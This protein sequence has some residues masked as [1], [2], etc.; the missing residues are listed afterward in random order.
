MLNH[1]VQLAVA[2][3]ASGVHVI[4][5]EIAD[6]VMAVTATE[7]LDRQL[8]YSLL[9]AS[10][11][12]EQ[13]HFTVFDQL[14]N[15]IFFMEGL[16]GHCSPSRELAKRIRE[17]DENPEPDALIQQLARE[18]TLEF[19]ESDQSRWL[20]KLN[21][22]DIMTERIMQQFD[23][24]GA[25]PGVTDGSL[26]GG[27]QA[28]GKI[29]DA[30]RQQVTGY[31]YSQR[32]SGQLILEG[33]NQLKFVPFN[34]S[35]PDEEKE[36]QAMIRKLAIRIATQTSSLKLSGG[37]DRMNF[38]KLMR[39]S[40]SS[41]GVPLDLCMEHLP[42]R[43]TR[44]YVLLDV[45]RSMQ[46]HVAFFLQMFFALSGE[47]ANIRA[48]VFVGRVTE[49]THLIDRD[50][51]S[52]SVHA[53]LQRSSAGHEGLTDYGGAI[54]D[55]NTFYGE[56]ITKRTTVI[57]LGDARTNRFDPREENL[58]DLRRRCGNLFWLNPEEKWSWGTGDSAM[59]KYLPYCHEAYV[60]R[61]LSQL[62]A[63]VEKLLLNAS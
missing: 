3:R 42:K 6:A 28:M 25:L 19:M 22:I 41:G 20:K 33:D 14:F 11:V 2:L 51:L 26:T 43:K 12:K 15:Q 44:L 57:I 55:F 46:D 27:G 38:R 1:I 45:S 13:R 62:E 40:L 54:E 30:V 9:R 5:S 16:A 23:G 60:V 53:L 56:E 10:M 29:T 24:Q 4:S 31:Q 18:L 63:F 59:K 39:K 50:A 7:T 37:K 32:P 34:R 47:F 21:A 49:I 36:L 8:F 35:S 58:M 52:E 61:N 17:I 48:F